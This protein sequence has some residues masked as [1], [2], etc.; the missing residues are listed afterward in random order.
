MT[1]AK[2]KYGELGRDNKLSLFV[3][4]TMC[5]LFFG[6]LQKRTLIR[7]ELGTL[8]TYYPLWSMGRQLLHW[9][10]FPFQPPGDA[11]SSSAGLSPKNN[12]Q[13][14]VADVCV[15]GKGRG[16]GEREIGEEN[17]KT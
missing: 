2:K 6:N 3:G 4:V 10:G 1:V 12:H 7:R 16:C 11:T 5:L 9:D 17:I 15:W 8:I 13:H 14:P